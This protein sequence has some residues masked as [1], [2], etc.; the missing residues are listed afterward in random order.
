MLKTVIVNSTPII[1]LSAVDRLNL[2]KDLYGTIII[3]SAVSN[4]I[5]AKNKS[6][7]QTQLEISSDWIQVKDI[8]NE[9]Q[10]QTFRTQLHEGEVEVLILGQ[11]LSADL[12]II[13]DYTARKYAKYHGFN[14]IGTVGIFLLA[15]SKG[16]VREIKPLV[17]DLISNGIFISS[18]LYAEIIKLADE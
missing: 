14:V 8:V 11:E 2:L 18:R 5:R 13:D 4:E 7:A 9:A 3:P 12:L 16:F 1:A 6:K 10:K 15:K 17:D